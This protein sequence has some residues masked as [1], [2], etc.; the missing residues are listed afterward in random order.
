L[1]GF[2]IYDTGDGACGIFV[3]SQIEE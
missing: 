3:A 2:F 1:Q